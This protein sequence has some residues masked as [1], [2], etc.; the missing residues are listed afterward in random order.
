MYKPRRSPETDNSG[1]RCFQKAKEFK[2]PNLPYGLAFLPGHSLYSSSS[3]YFKFFFSLTTDT[4]PFPTVNLLA[5]YVTE[6]IK[7]IRI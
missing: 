7:V 2:V 4:L 6:K 5:S 1:F 3:D